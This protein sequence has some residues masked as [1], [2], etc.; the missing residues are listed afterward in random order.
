MVIRLRRRSL[1][2]EWICQ[3]FVPDCCGRPV[4]RKYRHIIA[5]REYFFSDPVDKQ[6]HIAAR[7]IT[8]TNASGEKNIA[9][10]EQSVLARKE[11]KTARA[12]TRHLQDLEIGTEK[13]SVWYLFDQKIWFDWFDFERE[14]EVPK[15][16]AIGNHR[17]SKR[18]TSDLAMKL[19]FNP[20]NV[21]DV[22]DVPMC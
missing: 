2:Q 20:G 3:P 18:V 22:I 5:Q 13:I 14:P 4:T 1:S 11:T 10:N 15:E 8:A 17:R 9:T 21:L 7:Q 16:I 6:I 19:L 12:V